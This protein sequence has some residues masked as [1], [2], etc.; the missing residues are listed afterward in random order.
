MLD[1]R[2]KGLLDPGQKPGRVN[3]PGAAAVQRQFAEATIRSH[4]A[5]GVHLFVVIPLMENIA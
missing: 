5:A 1:F 3:P 2:S 4:A